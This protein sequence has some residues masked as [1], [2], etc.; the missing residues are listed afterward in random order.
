VR[1]YRTIHGGP[2]LLLTGL[3]ELH[4]NAQM[5]GG[6]DSTSFKIKFKQLERLGKKVIE[7]IS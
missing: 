4:S 7:R 1:P 3:C 5:F 6:I 2:V